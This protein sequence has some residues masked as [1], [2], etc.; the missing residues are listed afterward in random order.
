MSLSSQVTR[1]TSFS[2]DNQQ[3][4]HE[5]NFDDLDFSD[6]LF[7]ETQVCSKLRIPF[8]LSHKVTHS[9]PR[10]YQKLYKQSRLATVTTSWLE[11]PRLMVMSRWKPCAEI[12][13]HV[14]F[15]HRLDEVD[16]FINTEC[17]LPS[18][19]CHLSKNYHQL[20]SG[21][22]CFVPIRDHCCVWTYVTSDDF[23]PI[24]IEHFNHQQKGWYRF[25]INVSLVSYYPHQEDCHVSIIP[26]VG[27]VEYSST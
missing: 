3:F 11:L 9:Q 20:L 14:V 12:P 15:R 18:E 10:F 16:N 6:K 4:S 27:L 21:S 22:R 19:L 1:P 2:K 26:H 7:E 5:M 13:M 25:T 23:D 8:I 17:K 24:A